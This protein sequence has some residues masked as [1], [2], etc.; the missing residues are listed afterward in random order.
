MRNVL[1]VIFICCYSFASGQT[2]KVSV[3]NSPPLAYYGEEGNP[4]GL[5]IDI[6]NDIAAKESWTLDYEQ[7]KFSQGLNQ[8]RS[9][10]S[11]I[12][13]NVAITPERLEY[14]QYN[15]ISVYTTYGQ[16][17]TKLE[18]VETIHDLEGLK[19]GYIN[20][21][22]FA[23]EPE[24]GFIALLQQSGVSVDLL[25]FNSYNEMTTYL[26]DEIIDAGVY[27]RPYGFSRFL[28]ND[29]FEFQ[30]IFAAPIIFAPT[31]LYFGFPKGDFS[32][33]KQAIDRHLLSYRKDKNSVLYQAL[34][35]N[36]LS[37]EESVIPKWMVILLLLSLTGLILFFVFV[38]ILNTRVKQ[39]TKQIG[40]AN[41][42]I[43]ITNKKLSLALNAVKEGIWEW[44]I[45]SNEIEIDQYSYNV[46][47]YKKA[48]Q[49]VSWNDLISTIVPA[50]RKNFERSFKDHFSDNSEFHEISFRATTKEG[51][52]RWFF[53]HGTVVELDES[54]K[55]QR[56]LGT[57]VDI[58]DKKM[59]EEN[60]EESETREREKISKELHDGVQQ[61]LSAA[62]LNLNYVLENNGGKDADL[63][64]KKGIDNINTSIKE[65]RHLAHELNFNLAPA[66]QKLVDDLNEVTKTE[67]T[68]LTNLGSERLDHKIEKALYRIIQESI[69]NI[70]KHAEATKATIQLMK[71][72]D[73]VIL[74][75]EDNGK[76]FDTQQ[77]NEEFG[78]NSIRSRSRQIHGQLSIDSKIE[79]GTTITLEVPINEIE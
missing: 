16:I 30:E 18:Q 49:K 33:I 55:P 31:N 27:G 71:Y 42:E 8:L 23:I 67:L 41:L 14:V 12:L 15:D 13:V 66:I 40:E 34:R 21:D 79:K 32:T 46:M 24:E 38:G 76:G 2:I 39:K 25:P 5:F 59:L 48:G 20:N 36:L 10:S 64:I 28:I 56:Y 45:K 75:V 35:S 51:E 44:N 11:D 62:V 73:L 68:F 37:R 77:V 63:K 3:S 69:T 57:I 43:E 70:N 6:L 7:V 54:G 26:E 53:I 29:F 47:G 17:F 1:P 58:N 50:D 60:L 9:S 22:Y 65:I 19:I 61:T 74:T 4:K 78:L 52:V 72:P